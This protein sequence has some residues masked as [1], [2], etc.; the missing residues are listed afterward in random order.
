M[1]FVMLRI[2][3]E[4]IRTRV[5]GLSLAFLVRLHSDWYSGILFVVEEYDSIYLGEYY[6]T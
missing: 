1:S 5:R 2:F 4:F 3:E 6:N